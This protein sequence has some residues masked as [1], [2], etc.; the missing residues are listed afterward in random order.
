MFRSLLIALVLVCGAPLSA[1]AAS[2]KTIP[3][4][5]GLVIEA[6]VLTPQGP[7]KR[8]QVAIDADGT[9]TCVARRCAAP[10]AA[11]ILC[12][13]AVLTPGF[14]NLHEHGDYADT[15]P[16]GDSGVRYTHRHD[17]RKGTN[18]FAAA[19]SFGPT[20][21]PR[22]MAWGE[23][24]HLLAGETSQAG[25]VG[26]APGLLRNLDYADGDEG[27]P[28]PA[29][30]YDVFPLKDVSGILR[31][32][33]C[34]YGPAPMRQAVAGS[35]S[36][37]LP[38]VAEGVGDAARNEFACLT[39]KTFDTSPTGPDG[40][41]T[42]DTVLGAN[43]AIIHGVG[44]SAA[45][46]TEA[47]RLGVKII[48]SPRSNLALYGRT[49]DAR[50]AVDAGVTLALGTDWLF[51]GS[52]NLKR[53]IACARAVNAKAFAGRFS[54]RDFWA[55][56]TV[57]AALAAGRQGQI[58]VIAP[59][60]QADLV[61]VAAHGGDPYAAAIKAGFV[62]TLLELRGG[63]L[64][65][66]EPSMTPSREPGEGACVAK[67]A[68]FTYADLSK[69]MADAAIY[70]ALFEAAPPREPPCDLSRY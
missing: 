46:L 2:C 70:P 29:L 53:E 30:R 50:A 34:D 9:I 40:A 52:V 6:T 60:A 13:R 27:L 47:A 33:D 10:Q 11:R 31:N 19:E 64:I 44:L 20:K 66:G 26:F 62:D 37:Y 15:G 3:G 24:R 36:A 39:S 1:V 5:S 59:G 63:K 4:S 42:S 17:W 12:K 57:N 58:G 61:L 28:G 54:D 68:G 21:D 51:S 7:L 65:L 23:L 55:M 22:V 25:G 16:P 43:T 56:V 69:A 41:G 38:H 45:Q 67:D 8:A 48:W 35:Y 18:G 14:I 49:L 32:G